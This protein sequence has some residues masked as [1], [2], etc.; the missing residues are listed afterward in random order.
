M[1]KFR[2]L[3]YAHWKNDYGLSDA[4]IRARDK[5]TTNINCPVTIIIGLNDKKV[6]NDDAKKY[7]KKLL[8]NYKPNNSS[9]GDT[10][11]KNAVF[12]GSTSELSKM[13]KDMKNGE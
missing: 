10:N 12:V 9:S 6:S 8:S 1:R 4:D 3:L 5:L 13:I 7:Y 11:I 2:P